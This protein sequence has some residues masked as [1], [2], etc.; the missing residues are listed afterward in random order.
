MTFE[1]RDSER[2]LIEVIREFDFLRYVGY[3][4]RH[5]E[6]YNIAQWVEFGNEPADRVVMVA[7]EAEHEVFV[8]KTKYE[9]GDRL[10]PNP[11]FAVSEIYE[12]F[13]GDGPKVSRSGSI[14]ISEYSKFIQEHLM[15]V[16]TGEMWIDELLKKRG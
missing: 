8:M 11:G 6:V 15:P 13:C 12:R 1:L 5:F 2:F 9:W 7:T 3:T 4:N 10:V 14:W 16:I